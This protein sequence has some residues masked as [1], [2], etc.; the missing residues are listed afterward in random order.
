MT[1][2]VQV[3]EGGPWLPL[4]SVYEDVAVLGPVAGDNA[5]VESPLFDVVCAVCAGRVRVA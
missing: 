5:Y 1:V 3:A 4:D 2:H